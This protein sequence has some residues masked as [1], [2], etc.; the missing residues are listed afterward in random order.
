MI[1]GNDREIGE[2]NRNTAAKIRHENLPEFYSISGGFLPYFDAVGGDD[3]T[4]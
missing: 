4:K 3:V 2:K 1:G